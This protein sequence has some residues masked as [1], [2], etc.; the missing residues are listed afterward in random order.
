MN[1]LCR[2][3]ASGALCVVALGVAGADE[4]NQQDASPQE[5]EELRAFEARYALP[6]GVMLKRIAPPFIAERTT[7]VRLRIP[8][9]GNSLTPSPT[10]LFLQWRDQK[11]RPA[12]L[13]Y[14][15]NGPPLGE[16]LESLTGL[17][18]PE[19]E[20]E[21]SLLE[22]PISGDFIVRADETDE[23]IVAAL[24]PILRD[25]LKL[26]VRMT[27]R[28]EKQ[29]VIVA[30]GMFEFTPLP[31]HPNAIQIYVANSELGG[32]AVV[33]GRGD[34]ETLLQNVSRRI[35][36]RIV[37][38]LETSPEQYFDWMVRGGGR[39]PTADSIAH[40]LWLLENLS[41]QT[42]MKFAEAER[43]V[44]VLTIMRD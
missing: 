10:A 32:G 12:T 34:V 22:A 3:L 14:L 37:N 5:Q 35:G 23:R 13:F 31:E 21:A 43:E 26:P 25:E 44:R 33:A 7:F 38:E 39:D 29:P 17:M 42:G 6:E 30:S 18:P 16:V 19:V 2:V 20:A 15:Q 8:E 41:K 27:F 36:K 1:S 28:R 9:P 11:T 24:E 4:Q 40:A